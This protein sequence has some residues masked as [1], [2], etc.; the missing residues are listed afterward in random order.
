MASRL[1]DGFT[2]LGSVICKG[3]VKAASFSFSNNNQNAVSSLGTTTA[4]VSTSNDYYEVGVVNVQLSGAVTNTLAISYERNGRSL[5]I[6]HPT[7][8][9]TA[10]ATAGVQVAATEWPTRLSSP[11]GGSN[12]V[13]FL[14]NNGTNGVGIFQFLTTGVRMQWTSS[15]NLGAF[16]N[17]NTLSLFAASYTILLV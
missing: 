3:R 9:T 10:T 13:Y 8:S 6:W 4:V 14:N 16:A 11:G 7:L 2:S 15:T 5:T 1:D 12:F 17:G